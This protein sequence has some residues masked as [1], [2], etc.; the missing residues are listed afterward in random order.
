MATTAIN[1][2]EKTLGISQKGDVTAND[3]N[4]QHTPGTVWIMGD[5]RVF[6]YCRARSA[7]ALGQATTFYTDETQANVSVQVNL[8]AGYAAAYA[9][10]IIFDTVGSGLATA[11]ANSYRGFIATVNKDNV[12]REGDSYIVTTNTATT[13]TFD[14]GLDTALVDD[15]L[16]S[17]VSPW[18]VTGA[19]LVSD[20]LYG[21]AMATVTSGNYCWIQKKG[22]HL[23]ALF[24]TTSSDT[25]VNVEAGT[26][27]ITALGCSGT[28]G[29][30]EQITV[31]D[32]GVLTIAEINRF[33]NARAWP[34]VPLVGGTAANRRL[35]VVLDCVLTG[36]T[37]YI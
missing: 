8:A 31:S 14:R 15:D 5:G 35:P 2:K 17:L 21:L 11:A 1:W 26:T 36:A 13:L 7:L 29:Y 16:I 19:T 37:E 34:L 4:P 12:A 20:Q 33:K 22:I 3:S 9:G 28:D 30:L 18:D 24:R 25:Q 27:I 23:Q 32:P 6:Q 10:T